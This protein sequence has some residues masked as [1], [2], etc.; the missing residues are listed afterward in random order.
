MTGKNTFIDMHT[1]LFTARYLP[2]HSIFY[3]FFSKYWLSLGLAVLAVR[4]TRMSDFSRPA[5]EEPDQ[6]DLIDALLNHDVDQLMRAIAHPVREKIRE[7]QS[8]PNPSHRD[9]KDI[10]ELIR[11]LNDIDHDINYSRAGDLPIGV[12]LVGG[13]RISD[14]SAF[15]DSGTDPDLLDRFMAEAFRVAGQKAAESDFFHEAEHMR[16]GGLYKPGSDAGFR[17]A[18]IPTDQTGSIF[19]LLEFIV[20]MTLSERNR[21]KAL[22]RDFKKNG[23]P[24]DPEASLFV[25]VLLDMHRAFEKLKKPGM[26]GFLPPYFDFTEQMDRMQL[27]AA[28]NPNELINFGAVDPFRGGNWKQIVDSGVALGIT[29]YKIYPPLG[30]RPIDMRGYQ[31]PVASGRSLDKYRKKASNPAPY[32]MAQAKM[33]DII[34]HFS[35]RNLRL[36]AHCNPMG[37]QV[38]EGYGI[39]SDPE[40]WKHAM[41]THNA[42]NLWLFLAHGGGAK[43]VDWMGWAATNNFEQTF[44]YRAIRLVEEFDN[45][46]LGL[47]HILG[48]LD[49]KLKTKIFQRLKS[50]LVGKRTKNAPHHFRDKVCFG[51]DWAMPLMVGRTREYLIEFDT[52]FSDPQI[53]PC[54]PNFFEGNAKKFLGI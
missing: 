49:P 8:T 26:L 18:G 24:S 17:A 33:G 5:T 25:G 34:R 46:Y 51:T 21:F 31:T 20:I 14:R 29:G 45:V 4:V 40:L 6:D 48:I 41:E 32:P 44:A 47:G 22:K 54:A 53:S 12:Q 35:S 1:H 52:F 23:Q 37:F 7:F 10:E 9:W 42:R 50:V 16:S 2:L 27:L 28:E 36:F 13:G 3:L 11:A 39:Y 15:G 38:E 19:Q 43:E 30:I